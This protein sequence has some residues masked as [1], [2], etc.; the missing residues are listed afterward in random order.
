M[1]TLTIETPRRGGTYNVV[2][3]ATDGTFTTIAAY[4]TE[5]DA[6]WLLGR[7]QE[8]WKATDRAP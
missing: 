7:L 1:K 6:V 5:Q 4:T 3:T 2:A 8:R